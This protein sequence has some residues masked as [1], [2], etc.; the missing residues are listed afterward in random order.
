MKTKSEECLTLRE[1]REEVLGMPQTDVA[2]AAK[3]H[4]AWVSHVEGGH[5]PRR[6]KWDNLLK[7]YRLE[8]AEFSRLV[9]GAKAVKA[10]KQA[11]TLPLWEFAKV[12]GSVEQLVAS[13]E[14]RSA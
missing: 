14:V 1:Y 2:R 13:R 9:K 12:E 3:C 11:D 4:Q 8:P 5:L 6:W 7:A 10:L